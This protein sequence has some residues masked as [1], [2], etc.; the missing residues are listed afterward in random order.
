MLT[1]LYDGLI[2]DNLIDVKRMFLVF[3]IVNR[4]TLVNLNADFS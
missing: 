2:E 4:S 1:L 3:V